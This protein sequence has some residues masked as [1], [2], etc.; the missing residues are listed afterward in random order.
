MIGRI[1]TGEELKRAAQVGIIAEIPI[2]ARLMKV[3][4]D[5]RSLLLSQTNGFFQIIVVFMGLYLFA[6]V[7]L[8]ISLAIFFLRVITKQW[9]RNVVYVTT[10]VYTLYGITFGF[11]GVFQCGNPNH[12]LENQ[13]AGN[14]L[15]NS[16][17]QPMNYVSA[18]LNA[19][20][21]WVVS[22]AASSV[23]PGADI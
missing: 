3:S 11:M 23:S 9:H 7:V 5:V 4:R 1:E 2:I 14:C 18:S 16:T 12:F 20:T 22:F 13:F 6:C 8:K 17:L 21:D 10:A 15:P 19:L